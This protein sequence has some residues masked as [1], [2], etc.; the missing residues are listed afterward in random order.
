MVKIPGTSEDT[1]AVEEVA[2]DGVP[3]YATLYVRRY[4]QAT[5]FADCAH[6]ADSVYTSASAAV[7]GSPCCGSQASMR[8]PWPGLACTTRRPPSAST[9]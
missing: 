4:W 3:A 5:G 9:R 6:C 2:F 8:V 7:T 1:R